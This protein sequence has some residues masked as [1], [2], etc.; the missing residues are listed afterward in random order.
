[1][2]AV[3]PVS[4]YLAEFVGTFVLVLSV[5][6]NV[7]SG[8]ATW[9]VMSIASTLMVL[10]YALGGVSG[11]NLNPAVSISLGIANKLDW[12]NVGIYCV[13]QLLGG[14]MGGLCVNELLGKSM[15]L[16]PGHGY[17]WY[18]AALVEFVYTCMLCFVVLNVAASKP[19]AGKNEF[20]GLAIGFVVVAG[21]YGAGHISGACFNPAVALGVDVEVPETKFGI[22]WFLVYAWCEV[23]G[24]VVAAF[25]FIQCRPDEPYPEVVVDWNVRYPQRSVL[26][27]EFLGSYIL[28]FTVGLNVLGGSVA[29]VMSIASALLCMVFALGSVSGAHFN[30]AVTLAILSAGRR[31]ILTKDALNYMG[32]QLAGGFAGACTFWFVEGKTF[33]LT[34]APSYTLVEACFVE[35]VF[36]FFL[37]F[38]VL[39]V[40]T[41]EE[42]LSQ[43]FGL[44]IGAAI[45]AGGFAIGRISGGS[46]NPAVSFG[47]ALSH[48]FAVDLGR[49]KMIE[50]LCYMMAEWIG[51]ALAAA[52][53]MR[54]HTMEFVKKDE[55][56]VGPA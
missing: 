4:R 38:V 14:L 50:C 45:I 37:A 31:K 18:D 27:S 19:H 26:L 28:V 33:P 29:P 5:G 25:L 3:D 10:I 32:A 22:S 54:T 23:L 35:M 15:S 48:G 52:V 12:L 55:D 49:R 21:G 16:A 56:V 42:S 40:A 13:M 34:P 1:M 39:S 53:F 51:G 44:A 47:I 36:T 6:C 8:S 43:F 17:R 7:L 20:Y 9:A 2:V 46:L 11:A 41:V 30:P 24:G